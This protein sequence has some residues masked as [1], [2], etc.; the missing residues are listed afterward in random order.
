MKYLLIILLILV[1]AAVVTTIAVYYKCFHAPAPTQGDLYKIP[2][3]EQYAPYRQMIAR[4]IFDLSQEEYVPVETISFDGLILK[5]RM[6]RGRS[7]M[8]F[9]IGFHGYRSMAVHDYCGEAPH[10][11]E[12]GYN[13]IIV[14]QRGCGESEGHNITFGINERYDC[15]S[16][17]DFVKKNFGEDRKIFLSGISMG[18][19]TVLMAAGL[20]LPDNVVGIMADCGFTSPRDI[21]KKVAKDRKLPAGLMYPFARFAAKHFGHFD[22]EAASAVDAVKKTKVPILIAHG[23]DDR[24]VPYYMSTKL[25]EANPKMVKRECYPGAGHAISFMTDEQRYKYMT[26]DFMRVCLR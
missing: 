9:V 14:D 18:A 12:Q 16:W 3:N 21:I 8:P 10:L 20:D 7:D 22:L 2:D 4:M 13:L 6:Y 19:T 24:F 25:L 17:I 26:E 15:L 11:I 1:L 23:E 5:G